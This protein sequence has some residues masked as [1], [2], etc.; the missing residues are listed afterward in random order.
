MRYW[1]TGANAGRTD[2]I[3]THREDTGGALIEL[4][5]PPHA[6]VAAGE[7]ARLTAGCDKRF[8][9]CRAKFSNA[10]NFRGCPHMPGDDVLV[11]HAGSEAVRD[12]SAR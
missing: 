12:G 6:P 5:A 7:T 3:R 9:T 1:T 11:R 2:R 10:L 8:E 4:E